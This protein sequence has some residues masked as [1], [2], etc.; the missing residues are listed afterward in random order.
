MYHDV[1]RTPMRSVDRD[2]R[3]GVI[4][5]IAGFML[6]FS[7][8]F[9][10]PFLPFFLLWWLVVFFSLHLALV[11]ALLA[12]ISRAHIDRSARARAAHG[13]LRSL[14]HHHHRGADQMR[15]S[16]QRG[17]RR[18]INHQKGFKEIFLIKI[19]VSFFLSIETREKT[20]EKLGLYRS[21]GKETC[22]VKKGSFTTG[23]RLVLTRKKTNWRVRRR[24]P[25]LHCSCLPTRLFPPHKYP[26]KTRTAS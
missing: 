21:G 3:A 2:G 26:I 25:P 4:T 12:S 13:A 18:C 14:P 24:P 22:E 5:A 19:N 7:L 20:R 8:S 11:W 23:F 1:E 15:Q 16:C 9:C 17:V 10:W 6:F